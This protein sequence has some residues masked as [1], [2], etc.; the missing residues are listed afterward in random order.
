MDNVRCATAYVVPIH[1]VNV[2][3]SFGPQT[4]RKIVVA[5]LFT[6]AAHCNDSN[7]NPCASSND[8]YICFFLNFVLPH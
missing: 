4:E 7:N 1:S 8:N 3:N 2:P 5:E 6:H